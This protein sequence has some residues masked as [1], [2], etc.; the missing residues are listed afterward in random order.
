MRRL[1]IWV[2]LPVGL[3]A[4][5]IG[6]ALF[7][8]W[9]LFTSSHLDEP[10]PQAVTSPIETPTPTV[11]TGTPTSSAPSGPVV[12]AE[13]TFVSQEHDTAGTARVLELTDGSRVLRLEGFVTSDGPDVH[14]WLSDAPAGGEW[15]IYDDG[16]YVALGE[17]KATE[18][19]HNYVIPPDADLT[20]LRSAVIWCD[21]FNVAFGS[22]P[23]AL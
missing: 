10:V 11:S 15:D 13:G 20:G 17:I 9:R 19:N 16:R 18:G 22:A 6:L 12:L 21:R 4:V 3:A 8:P 1:L 2:G 7:E 5:A 14:V 23:L